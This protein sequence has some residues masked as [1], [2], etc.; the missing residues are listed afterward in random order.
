MGFWRNVAF[1]QISGTVLSLLIALAAAGFTG[2][3]WYETRNALLL[4]TKPHVDFDIEDDPDE[5]P[6]GI[7]VT[8]AGS[9]PVIAG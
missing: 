6:V 7:A 5:P 1:W 2:M 8:N 3:Q 9:S 4:S